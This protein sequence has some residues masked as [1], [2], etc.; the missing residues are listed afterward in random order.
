MHPARPEVRLAAALVD[1]RLEPLVLAAPNVGELDPLAAG[2]GL[3]VEEH[4]QVEALRDSLPERAGQL[5]R[6]VH[7]RGAQR[8]PRDHIDRADARMLPRVL[9]HVDLV[10]RR[11]EEALEGLAYRARWPASVNTD[12]LWLASLVRSSR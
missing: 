2:R 6:L 8:H 1:L 11:T 7:R 9:L 3:R 10:D 12:R 4:R 5:D